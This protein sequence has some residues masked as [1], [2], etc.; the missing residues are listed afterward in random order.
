VRTCEA[1]GRRIRLALDRPSLTLEEGRWVVMVAAPAQRFVTIGLAGAVDALRY[2]DVLAPRPMKRLR[3][4]SLDD[5]G[6]L[7][8][9][10]SFETSAE[11]D[12]LVV[13]LDVAAP[14]T[15]MRSVADPKAI[16]PPPAKALKLG[17]AS[18][19]PLVGLPSPI[20]SREGYFLQAPPRYLFV[21]SDVAAA[22]RHA[23]M[24]TRRRFRGGKI[25]VGD[26]SQWNGARPAADLGKP[27]HI[28]HV[29]GRD[30]DIG[31]PVTQGTSTLTR[32]CEGVLVDEKVLKCGPGT[33]EDLDAMRLA[34]FL[35][36]LIDG[37]TPGG[38]HIANPDRR[39]GPI[40]MVETI[41]TDQ[42]YIDEIRK[43]LPKLRAKRWIHE[44]A[45]GALGE[46][47]L[48]RASPWHVDH[49]HVRFIGEKAETPKPLAFEP[50]PSYRQKDEV[51]KD[52]AE[53]QR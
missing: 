39:P 44:E 24:Q 6:R 35:G 45:F 34:Y 8:T 1:P 20:S 16:E 19:R 37:P 7:P 42:A 31:L 49:V 52:R 14:V 38:R 26:C 10:V 43:A 25:G 28:S 18:P 12:D 41:F 2:F 53:A 11:V 17:E 9:F 27:R 4:G 3:A 5:D 47:G 30:V 50:S 40:A 15:L 51:A 22:L 21:R 13:V 32:R 29:G 36:L 33:V 48:L 23:F 46:E